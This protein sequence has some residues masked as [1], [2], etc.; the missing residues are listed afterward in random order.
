[1]KPEIIMRKGNLIDDYPGSRSSRSFC[2][3]SHSVC[4]LVFLLTLAPSVTSQSHS[5][6]KRELS[7][8]FEIRYFTDDPRANGETDF[9]G[10][11]SIFDTDQRIEY[12]QAYADFASRY[13][14]DPHLDQL[15]VSDLEIQD[16]IKRLKPQPLPE[17]RQRIPLTG[18]KFL[19][20]KPGK[21]EAQISAIDEWNSI[22]GIELQNGVLRFAGSRTILD[23]EIEEQDWRM[24]IQWRFRVP[25]SET[26]PVRFSLGDAIEAGINGDGRYYFLTDS[27]LTEGSRA[28]T[29]DWILSRFELDL[30]TGKFNWYI[31]DEIVAD[32]V[33]LHHPV[34]SVS[35]YTIEAGN[36][37]QI[38]DLWG[39]SY[40]KTYDPDGDRHTRD[41]PFS[42]NTFLDETFEVIPDIT[43]WQ[44]P[45]YDDHQ[46]KPVPHWPYA[47][48][49]ERHRGEDLYLRKWVPVGSFQRALL[50]VEKLRPGG[51][52]WVNGEVVAVRDNTHPFSVDLTD[53]LDPDS[54][55]LIAIRVRPYHLKYTMRHTPADEHSGWFAGRMWLDLKDDRR[56]TDV[57]VYT[58][59]LEENSAILGLEISIRNDHVLFPE[60]RERSQRQSNSFEGYLAIK[61]Y[62]WFPKEQSKPVAA[63]KV[64]LYVY[65]GQ[66]KKWTGTMKVPDPALWTS[67]DPKLHKLVVQL[68]NRDGDVIDDEVVT[69]GIRTV[70]QEGGTFRINGQPEM[71]NGALIFGFRAPFERIAQ[72]LWRAPDEQLVA[73]ILMLKKMN[74]NAA[75]ISIHDGPAGSMNDPRY[76][77]I[78][79]QLGIMYQWATTSWVRTD[80]PHLLDFEG[81]PEYVR[82]VRN[83]PGI[84]MWQPANHPSFRGRNLDDYELAQQ[85]FEDY[86]QWIEKIYQ[87]ITQHDRSRLIS[88][89]A[90]MSRIKGLRNDAGT[91]DYLGNPVETNP[92]WTAPLLVRGSMDHALGFGSEWSDLRNFPYPD[93]W[94][95]DQNIRE[96]GFRSDYL[97]SKERAY[98]D[99]ES[100]ETIGQPNWHLHRGKPTYRVMSYEWRMDVGS[101]GRYLTTDEWRI[102]QA[103]QAL[104]AAEAYRKKRWLDYDGLAWCPLRGGGNTGTYLKPLIDYFGHAKLSYYTARMAFQ[105]VLA[106]SN[107][108]D[109]AYGPQD[110]IT[111][112]VMNLGP[113]RI[114]NV[115]TRVLSM[116]GTLV[117]EKM[118][119]Q[120]ELQSGRTVQTLE[121]W[122]PSV[123]HNGL[124]AIEY[125]VHSSD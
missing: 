20:S 26:L 52:I 7:R 66:N 56:I 51:E 9:K 8:A 14:G 36:G 55:N 64:P 78:G 15:V 37:M 97:A 111:P 94:E 83:H 114:V 30:A 41:V 101:I 100:E 58:D 12:L 49:G 21:R 75:R 91:L 77:E 93:E 86:L 60:Q 39:V 99:F 116:D 123:P 19:G 125:I 118:F 63:L 113:G 106:G 35:R 33:A 89:V 109:I 110:N 54:D 42:I 90:S 18:W 102:S 46:W 25:S 61:L 80:S 98:F 31:D 117:D 17:V 73:D 107:N 11:T 23:Q 79:D 103:W 10:N 84:V 112:I 85:G 43:D 16:A 96:R 69:T 115:K 38:D 62:K 104:S 121:S 22:P 53:F 95:D 122:R 65:L 124:F 88:P 71:M 34:N 13:F 45:R 27:K 74:A 40:R 4:F 28:K 72:W 67:Y 87:S 3:Y 59:T 92:I 120:V 32:F 70:S 48:G 119:H 29:G 47:H 1:M 24:S 76:A 50:R 6:N 68:I 5:N 57:F 82:Q 81:F 2:F 44:H 108:V 105:R